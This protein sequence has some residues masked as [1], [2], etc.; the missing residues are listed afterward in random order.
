MLGFLIIKIKIKKKDMKKNIK[1]LKERI[2]FIKDYNSKPKNKNK[3]HPI[4]RGYCKRCDINLYGRNKKPI[5]AC[6]LVGCKVC[7]LSS[8]IC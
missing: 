6:D 2:Q 8:L 1:T 3:Q 7:D 5:T 4:P